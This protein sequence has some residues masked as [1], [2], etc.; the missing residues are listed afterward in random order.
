MMF[1]LRQALFCGLM[2]SATPLLAQPATDPAA[3]FGARESVAS[4]VISPS[5]RNIAF[6][7]A[8]DGGSYV[9]QTV[10][11]TNPTP[12]IAGHSD[13]NQ[14][15]T[16]CDF[17]TDDRLVCSLTSIVDLGGDITTYTQLISVNTDG[18]NITRIGERNTLDQLYARLWSGRIIDYAGGAPNTVLMEQLFVPEQGAGTIL[19]RTR[20]GLGVVRLDTRTL[21]ATTVEA[22]RDAAEDF[23]SDGQGHVRILAVRDTLGTGQVT[24]RTKYMYRRANGGDWQEFSTYD[25]GTREGMRPVAVDPD[26]N[27]AYTF[28]KLNG[29][30]ALYRVSLDGSLRRELVASND[31]VDVDDLITFGRRQRVVGASYATE[32]RH[33]IYFQPELREMLQRLAGALPGRDTMDI[34]D[35][36]DDE[37]KLLI[38]AGSDNDPGQYYLY[39]RT[40]RRLSPLAAIRPALA[41]IPL[42]HVRPITYRAQDGTSIPA[43]LTLP[44]GSSGRGLPALV[45]PHGGPSARDEWGFDWLAQYFANRGFAV[46]QPNY[47]G[48]SGYGDQWFRENGFR[49]W[50]TAIGDVNDAGRWLVSEGIADPAKLA[51][52]GWSYGG[53]AAL[54]SSVL[55][56][57]LFKAV[58]AVAPVT[59]LASARDAAQ[60]TSAARVVRDFFGTGPHIAE[61]SP[62]QHADAIRAPV[63]MFHGTRDL[64]VA[65]DQ[66]R[67]MD[68]RLRAAGKTSELIVYPE[69]DHQLDDN[70]ARADM[71]RRSDAFLRRALGLGE[72]AAAPARPAS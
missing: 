40:A 26:L 2:A 12:R 39:D 38:L 22:P 54:Q 52:F 61:G 34:V 48:S 50:R 55:D 64:N 3:A 60:N 42:A 25:D 19:N 56:A 27:V 37:T 30:M 24:N 18:S 1:R 5:G 58:V 20:Q 47:R 6:I 33:A 46:L 16:H 29:R 15:L 44:P 41:G 66:S 53:Y 68:Q 10:D 23:I 8:G 17:I 4:M 49:A 28:I 72:P 36:N 14:R 9:L 63:L 13:R 57:N 32:R 67:L 71:L 51:I 62:A 43:Y 35:G 45:L 11:L 70:A 31:Q 65:I 69:L 7:S 59:D 21:R